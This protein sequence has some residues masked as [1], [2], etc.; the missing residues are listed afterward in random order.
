MAGLPWAQG[1]GRSLQGNVPVPQGSRILCAMNCA[2]VCKCLFQEEICSERSLKPQGAMVCKSMRIC[3]V[4]FPSRR[5]SQK[6]PAPQGQP[7]S[8]L[9]CPRLEGC[10][11]GVS[12]KPGGRSPE[13]RV[14][15][16][17]PGTIFTDVHF[18][19][20]S[21]NASPAP[22]RHRPK[23]SLRPEDACPHSRVLP[24]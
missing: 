8:L 13:A 1:Q 4:S 9:F 15:A 18:N 23:D 20:F 11:G 19:S 5:F 2:Y 16:R 17:C 14:E 10:A 7:A 22:Q 3:G 12:G 21:T 6:G 24:L